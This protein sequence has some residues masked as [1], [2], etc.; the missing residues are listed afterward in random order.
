MNRRATFLLLV[1]FLALFSVNAFSVN[2]LSMRRGGKRIDLPIKTISWNAD[3]QF[4]EGQRGLGDTF[5]YIA[6]GGVE[7]APSSLKNFVNEKIKTPQAA[8]D[9][10]RLFVAGPLVED[11]AKAKKMLE[12]GAAL[13]KKL[14]YL[15]IDLSG[16][17]PESYAASAVAWSKDEASAWRVSLV[18]FEMDRML[19]LVHVTAKVTAAG[20]VTMTRHPMVNGPMMT[21]QTAMI[22][23]DSKAEERAAVEQQR[24]MR[25]EARA[26]RRHYAKAL[27]PDRTLDAAW[28]FA[29]ARLGGGEVADLWGEWD[30][31]VGRGVAYKVYDLKG[32][33]A[34][35]YSDAHV[36]P[37]IVS[38]FHVKH[39]PA[40]KPGKPAPR[41]GPVLHILAQR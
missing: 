28:T 2:A 21:W 20:E 6:I 39:V 26:A 34:V 31:V 29:R 17:R 8:I 15:A 32:G 24:A 22:V 16:H 10:V 19:R 37:G 36:R 40:N 5:P 9:A 12:A 13:K 33:G 38:F 30:R 25:L 3:V 4:V 27:T 35:L 1:P 7:L 41:I 18:A 11:E 23:S 14:K